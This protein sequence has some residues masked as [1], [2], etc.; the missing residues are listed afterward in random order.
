VF[1][2]ALA[3]A[4][5]G[6]VT[7][8]RRDADRPEHLHPG[9]LE[10]ELGYL[11]LS[12]AWGHGYAAEACAAALEWLAGALPGEPVVLST[13]TANERS[14]RLAAKLGFTAVERFE[15]HGAEQWF[16]VRRSRHRTSDEKRVR[17]AS[18]LAV[19]RRQ[20]SPSPVR[21]RAKP[22]GRAIGVRRAS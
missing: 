21:P 9:G 12:E 2:V 18:D 14:L 1:V 15:E 22:W 17:L 5:V 13:Q 20:G 10:V 8:D 16:G 7:I 11:F 3:R 19:K 6:V 4:A